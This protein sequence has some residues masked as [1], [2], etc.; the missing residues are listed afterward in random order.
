PRLLIEK[1]MTAESTIKALEVA[2]ER[3]EKLRSFEAGPLEELLRPLAAELGLKTGQLF[4]ALR[5]ATTGRTAAPP[6]F[7]TMAVLGKE[8]CLKR[9][10][11]ALGKLRTL[12][13]T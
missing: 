6:L 11:A 5:T 2:R 13:T 1:N 8:C 12:F 3:L 10:D 9:I 4:G 7:Q